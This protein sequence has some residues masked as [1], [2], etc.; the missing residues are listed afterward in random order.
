M[1]RAFNSAKLGMEAC[2][3]RL[4]IQGENI[5]NSDTVGYKTRSVSFSDALYSA[6]ATANGGELSF[7]NG[8]KPDGIVFSPQQGASENTGRPLDVMIDGN[9]Y[10]CVQGADGSFS[11]TRGGNF[12]VSGDGWL[13]SADGNYV[14]DPK[15][16]RIPIDNE[17]TVIFTPSEQ[18]AKGQTAIGVF[19]FLNQSG[20]IP[21][22]DSMFAADTVSGAPI[23]DPDAALHQ[24]ALERSSVD[25]AKE[26]TQMI[27]AQRGFQVNARMVQASDEIEDT[28]NHLME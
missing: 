26:M 1:I 6:A 19:T 12:R 3:N 11:Y 23:Q 16:Q 27:K 17:E 8:V 4:G 24:R 22:G 5:S 9:G 15:L 18:N 25:M 13:V 20:L 7:G 10:F 14:M 2:L 21:K 28:A